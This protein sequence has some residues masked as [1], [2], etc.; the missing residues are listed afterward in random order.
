MREDGA[1]NQKSEI[2]FRMIG[3]G[4]KL[5]DSA[6][7]RSIKGVQPFKNACISAIQR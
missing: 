4:L 3:S 2:N 5:V 1:E 7:L 6:T